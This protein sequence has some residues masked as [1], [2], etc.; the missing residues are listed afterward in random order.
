[1][2]PLRL[3]VADAHASTFGRISSLSSVATVGA[4]TT[5]GKNAPKN[6]QSVTA[7]IPS[8]IALKTTEC[9]VRR[10]FGKGNV[11]SSDA[12]L[13]ESTPATSRWQCHWPITQKH[14]LEGRHGA[15]IIT[16]QRQDS[17]KSGR[18]YFTHACSSSLTVPR[19][20]RETGVAL[21]IIRMQCS[22]SLRVL[23]PPSFIT[24]EPSLSGK[25]LGCPQACSTVPG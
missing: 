6:D 13:P 25:I 19:E 7:R 20:E 2:Q 3:T 10:R 5:T 12:T 8:S 15:G 23:A 9:N 22:P 24:N 18:L 4:G 16:T 17:R 1:M 11:L 21:I 14:V